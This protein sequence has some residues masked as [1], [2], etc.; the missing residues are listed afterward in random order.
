MVCVCVCVPS[1]SDRTLFIHRANLRRSGL[2]R[3]GETKMKLTSQ[4]SSTQ[5]LGPAKM[6]QSGALLNRWLPIWLPTPTRKGTLKFTPSFLLWKTLRTRIFCGFY[7]S[8]SPCC[9]FF[10]DCHSFWCATGDPQTRRVFTT[11]RTTGARS[12]HAA[13]AGAGG[14]AAA[15]PLPQGMS[16]WEVFAFFLTIYIYILLCVVLLVVVLDLNVEC[17]WFRLCLLWF[18]LYYGWLLGNSCFPC[19]LVDLCKR[20]LSCSKP[21]F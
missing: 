18:K 4:L 14:A 3:G 2:K 17:L 21:T 16:C 8:S 12:A 19:L 7:T 15:A 11:R 1:P 10:L 20:I 13:A 9:S 5:L 6:V